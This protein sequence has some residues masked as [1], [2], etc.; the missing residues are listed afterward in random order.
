MPRAISLLWG[1]FE[2]L[3]YAKARCNHCGSILGC[4]GGSTT[5]LKRHLES[6]HVGEA[7]KLEQAEVERTRSQPLPSTSHSGLAG[8]M[9]FDTKRTNLV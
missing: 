2:K 8:Y 3:E 5:A 4:A 6:K 1:H 7:G 9:A